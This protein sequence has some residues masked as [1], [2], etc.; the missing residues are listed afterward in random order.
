MVCGATGLAHRIPAKHIAPVALLALAVQGAGMAG[1]TAWAILPVAFA[2]YVIGGVGHGVKNVL[3]RTLIQERIAREQHGRAFAAYGAARNAAE[4]GALGLG[5]VMVATLGAQ[6]ALLIAGLGPV[7]AGLLA[8]AYRP[9]SS[10]AL[11]RRI[12][13]ATSSGSPSP[14][15]SATQA[16]GSNI[17]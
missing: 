12:A 15:N 14:S 4:L 7:V 8:I 10:T 17:G 13:P 3:M 1:Q 2:G 5:G 6:P 16:S 11:S 9:S